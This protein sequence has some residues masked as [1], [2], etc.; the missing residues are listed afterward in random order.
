MKVAS[1]ERKDKTI[2]IVFE[3]EMDCV[4][5]FMELIDRWKGDVK[6]RPVDYTNKQLDKP[7]PDYD[8]TWY[9]PP[10]DRLF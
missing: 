10:E 5:L 9:T 7:K 1:M 6:T 8:F 2:R 4:D 3:H